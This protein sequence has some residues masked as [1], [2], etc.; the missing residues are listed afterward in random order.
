[1]KR[2]IIFHLIPQRGIGGV[3]KAAESCQEIENDKY[4]SIVFMNFES[5]Q[6]NINFYNSSN[7]IIKHWS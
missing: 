2:K 3:E 1:M 4:Q 6:E 7:I 5:K